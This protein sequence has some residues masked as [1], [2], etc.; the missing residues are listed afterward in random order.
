MRIERGHGNDEAWRRR[1]CAALAAI[2][3]DDV[4]S[5]ERENIALP[6]VDGVAQ[7]VAL[8]RRVMP[9]A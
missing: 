6:P 1:F 3:Y 8:L 4:L 9:G 5:I 7:S 2:G